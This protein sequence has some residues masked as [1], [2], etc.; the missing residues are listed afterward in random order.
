MK[1]R[2]STSKSRVLNYEENLGSLGSF[3]G[4]Y[5]VVSEKDVISEYTFDLY[6]GQ[7]GTLDLDKEYMPTIERLIIPKFRDL[8]KHYAKGAIEKLYSLGIYSDASNFFSPNT[9]MKRIDFTT[10]IGKAVDLRVM[11]EPKTKN[12]HQLLVFLKMLNVR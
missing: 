3:D 8:S 9:P 4:G 11:E 5:A 7:K 6:S 2:L 1:N 10:A 12:R